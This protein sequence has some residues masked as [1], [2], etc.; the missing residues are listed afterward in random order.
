[1]LA[2][3]LVGLLAA[4]PPGASQAAPQGIEQG[5]ATGQTSSPEQQPTPGPPSTPGASA[6]T[7]APAPPVAAPRPPDRDPR[8]NSLRRGELLTPEGIT[9]DRA[10]FAERAARADFILIGESHANRCDHL[11]QASLL[12]GL[13]HRGLRPVVGLEMIPVDQRAIVDLFNQ[14]RIEPESLGEALAWPTLWGF[15]YELYEPVFQVARRFELPIAALNVP[16]NVARMVLDGKVKPDEVKPRWL[17]PRVIILSPPA[18]EP[19]LRRVFDAHRSLG[20]GTR[21][22]E[23]APRALEEDFERF[24]LA[25]SLWDSKMALEAMDASEKHGGPVVILAGIRHV[26]HGWGIA[27]RLHVLSPGA[28][29]LTVLP[30]RGGEQPEAGAADLFFY[31][32]ETPDD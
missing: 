7:E 10:D 11:I 19:E 30:W 26:E 20:H 27:H 8:A 5:R 23:S 13:A 15:D 21:R 22:E 25:Q 4:L 28:R 3:A 17:L 24:V 12:A 9:L 16:K 18:Q 14:G 31:C 29:L 1:M 2:L 6:E 32:P